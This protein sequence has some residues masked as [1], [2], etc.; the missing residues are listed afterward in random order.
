MT[1]PQPETSQTARRGRPAKYGVGTPTPL[2]VPQPVEAVDIPQ[3]S[4]PGIKCPGC[5][6]PIKPRRERSDGR[7][8]YASCPVCLAR[9]VLTIDGQRFTHVRLIA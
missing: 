3:P 6:R 8:C 4:E 1:D 9:M 5:A 2:P 7:K